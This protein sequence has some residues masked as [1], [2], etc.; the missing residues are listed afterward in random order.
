MKFDPRHDPKHRERLNAQG[1]WPDRI[2]TDLMDAAVA[3]RPDHIAVTDVNTATGRST[4]LSYRELR[5]IS[6]RIALGLVSMG[7]QRN[8][9]VSVQLPNWWHFAGLYLACVRIGAV[10]N[11]LM[12]IFREREMSFMLGFCE[13]KLVV[14]PRRFRGFD[15][16]AMIR[17]I[18][19]DLPHLKGMLV[20]DGED[21]ATSFEAQLI[22][23]RW[24]D[25]MDARK[26]FAERRPGPD[27][28]CELI[29]TSGTTG[30][31]KGVMHTANTLISNIEQAGRQVGLNSDDVVFM[32]SP[33]AHQTGFLYGMMLPIYYKTKSVLQDIWDAVVAAQRIQDEGATFTMASTP[34]LADLTHNEGVAKYDT[35]TLRNFICAGASI[36]TVLAQAAAEKLRIRVI[37]GWGMSENGLVT[38]TRIGDAPEKVF[39]TDGAPIT[40]MEIRVV[41]SD[42]RLLPPNTEG[43]LQARGLTS[44]VGYLKKPELDTTD[45]DGWFDTGDNAR[46]DPDGYV[47]I[48]GRS[49]DIIIRGGENIP[50]VEVEELLY[51]HPDVQDASIVGMPDERLGERGCAFLVLKPGR[52]MTFQDMVSYFSDMKLAKNYWPERM[53]VLTEMPRTPSGKIQKF[54]LR[55]VAKELASA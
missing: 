45:A 49:K 3:A 46:I 14:V 39:Q 21:E 38:T 52:S 37:S 1:L 15:H 22:N 11:P 18:R 36:P 20:V 8:D 10:I 33:I 26:I 29:Y 47:R 7:V 48:T 43:H 19:K 53:E 23:R 34:F 4:T 16:P 17:N 25:E 2:I 41:D 40:G 13:A 27:D 31:P 30:Q 5:T 9:V 55:E 44:F 6:D 54:K 12:P 50:V 35:S 32:A 24:E 28:V 51:R 42:G